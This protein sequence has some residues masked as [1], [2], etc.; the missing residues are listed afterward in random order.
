MRWE[1]GAAESCGEVRK[2][3]DE[4]GAPIE[5]EVQVLDVAKVAEFVVDVVLLR[6]LVQARDEDD[7]PLDS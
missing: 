4:T 2:D 3:L 7:P 5:V 1:R 6:L